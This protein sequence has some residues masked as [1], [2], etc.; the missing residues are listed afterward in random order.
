MEFQ[1]EQLLIVSNISSYTT[2]CLEESSIVSSTSSNSSESIEEITEEEES[3][4]SSNSNKP[5]YSHI[6]KKNN[7]TVNYPYNSLEQFF[8]S[9][10]L[11]L[12]N[13]IDE[14]FQDVFE[15]SRAG[16]F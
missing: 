9:K 15:C 3:I 11:A 13:C 6:Y 10:D 8:D 4:I 2:I 12:G 7:T 16:T 5:K 1:R 14:T